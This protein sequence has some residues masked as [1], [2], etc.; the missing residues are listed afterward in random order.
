MKPNLSTLTDSE[1]R[2][3]FEALCLEQEKWIDPENTRKYGKLFFD[4]KD[5]IDELK[6]RPGDARHILMPY[7][8]HPNWQVRLVTGQYVYALAPEETRPVLQWFR[9]SGHAY[10][11]GNAGMFLRAIE[12]GEFYPS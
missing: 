4:I 7:L 5:V 8:H 9:T 11:Q 3:R 12:T 1:L 2:L 6:R 10:Y